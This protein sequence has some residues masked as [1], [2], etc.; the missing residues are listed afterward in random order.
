MGAEGEEAKFCQCLHSREAGTGAAGSSLSEQEHLQVEREEALLWRRDFL[1]PGAEEQREVWSGRGEVGTRSFWKDRVTSRTLLSVG[2]VEWVSAGPQWGQF[3]QGQ[4]DYFMPRFH[5]CCPQPGSWDGAHLGL[6]CPARQWRLTGSALLSWLS[7]TRPCS[8]LEEL[9]INSRQDKHTCVPWNA[10]GVGLV[11]PTEKHLLS[12]APH[13][14]SE[15]RDGGIN[16]WQQK[17]G[18]STLDDGPGG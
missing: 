16:I 13:S 10:E 4:P 11:V 2:R 17:E 8:S 9:K 18:S 14:P 6:H 7:F 1:S 15:T 12:L 5:Y 3:Q